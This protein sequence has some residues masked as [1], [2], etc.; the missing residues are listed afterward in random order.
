VDS[1]PLDIQRWPAAGRFVTRTVS[2]YTS[3]RD[4][5]LPREA[6]FGMIIRGQLK[7]HIDRTYPLE[8][9]AEAQKALAS[10]QTV[11]KLLLIP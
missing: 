1:P 11:G 10:R 5:P 9:A 8:Q 7:L 4:E 2:S 6:V 3:T